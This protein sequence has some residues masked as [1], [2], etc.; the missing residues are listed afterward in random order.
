[1]NFGIRETLVEE[2]GFQTEKDMKLTPKLNTGEAT[3]KQQ[4][5]FLKQTKTVNVNSDLKTGSL[6]FR[7]KSQVNRPES[8]LIRKT[9]ASDSFGT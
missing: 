7:Q 6:R 8:T 4:R 3:E 5:T 1:M 9:Q 2:S